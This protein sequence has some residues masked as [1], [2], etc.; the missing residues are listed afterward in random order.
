[1]YVCTT[2]G[3]IAD[4][5]SEFAAGLE[6]MNFSKELGIRTKRSSH[7]MIF[8]EAIATIEGG[9]PPHSGSNY[10]HLVAYEEVFIGHMKTSSMCSTTEI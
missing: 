6:I 1:M 7:G 5:N 9:V 2:V 3:S 8:A 4:K 10:L